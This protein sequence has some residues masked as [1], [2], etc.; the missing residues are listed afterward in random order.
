M[1]VK[2]VNLYPSLKPVEHE[3]SNDNEEFEL[4]VGQPNVRYS[5]I[6]THCR[7]PM[8]VNYELMNFQHSSVTA[9]KRPNCPG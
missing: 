8:P 1:S 5:I 3:H 9:A 4:N 6:T 7:Y 2:S